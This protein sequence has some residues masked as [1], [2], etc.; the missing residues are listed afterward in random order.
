MAYNKSRS[1]KNLAVKKL[2]QAKEIFSK[3]I[4]DENVT[5]DEFLKL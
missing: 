1:F 5:H 4:D 3:M 2:K